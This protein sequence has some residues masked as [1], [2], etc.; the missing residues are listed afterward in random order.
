MLVEVGV[1]MEL[2]VAALVVLVEERRG[3]AHILRLRL[4]LLLQILVAVVAVKE[5]MAVVLAAQEVLA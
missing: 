3:L 2:L 1:A 5:I 4:A